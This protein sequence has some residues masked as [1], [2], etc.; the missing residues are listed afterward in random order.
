MVGR[1]RKIHLGNISREI[2]ISLLFIEVKFRISSEVMDSQLVDNASENLFVN[3][4]LSVHIMASFHEVP[5]IF[6]DV[7]NTHGTP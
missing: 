7:V 3:K 2:P 4:L 1:Q 6:S 5:I